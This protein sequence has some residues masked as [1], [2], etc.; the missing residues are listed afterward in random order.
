MRRKTLKTEYVMLALLVA[1]L[2]V[3]P[4]GNQ[5]CQ[6]KPVDSVAIKT[7]RV[8]PQEEIIPT[9]VLVNINTATA[10]ELTELPNI[11][12]VLAAR[13]VAYRTEHGSFERIEDLQNVC[14]IGE[15]TIAGLAGK[16]TTEGSIS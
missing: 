9:P 13:I 5:L 8:A 7:S 2:L 16:I 4:L 3:V 10:D 1:F 6:P 12:D 11:G 14:G 15:K